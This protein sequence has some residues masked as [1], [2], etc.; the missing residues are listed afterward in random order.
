MSI[1]DALVPKQVPGQLI[2]SRVEDEIVPEQQLELMQNI[3]DQIV[4]P[5]CKRSGLIVVALEKNNIGPIFMQEEIALNTPVFFAVATG[6]TLTC[7]EGV[8]R[9]FNPKLGD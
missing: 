8:A 9:G 3:G 1:K 4:P 7:T 6:S 5:P 2:P